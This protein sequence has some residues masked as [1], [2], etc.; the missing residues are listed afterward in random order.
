MISL[1]HGQ[2]IGFANLMRFMVGY[3]LKNKA[4]EIIIRL[5]RCIIIILT[6]DSSKSKSSLSP[7]EEGNVNYEGACD[8]IVL[9]ISKLAGLRS[10]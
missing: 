8:V 7:L 4:E 9:G 5:N 10:H 3:G 2:Q 1:S 6:W